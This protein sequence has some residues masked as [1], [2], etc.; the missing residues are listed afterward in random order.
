MNFDTEQRDYMSQLLSSVDRRIDELDRWVR[1][2]M[3]SHMLTFG[4]VVLV[5]ASGR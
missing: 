4:L 5:A 2:L 3:V 1:L